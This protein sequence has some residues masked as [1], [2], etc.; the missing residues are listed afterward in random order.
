MKQTKEEAR[1]LLITELKER[2]KAKWLVLH[3]EKHLKDMKI[4][5]KVLCKICNKDID[6]IAE[7][8]MNNIEDIMN[9]GTGTI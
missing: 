4:D 7:E 1:E 9:G 8:Q 5:G 2:N 6:E 3:I